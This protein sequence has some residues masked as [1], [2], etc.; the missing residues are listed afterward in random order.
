MKRKDFKQLLLEHIITFNFSKDKKMKR[1]ETKLY[2]QVTADKY[3]LPMLVEDDLE[4][5]CKKLGISK[6][7]C[8]QIICREDGSR[9]GYRIV[10]IVVNDDEE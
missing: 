1:N 6:D 5:F 8:W 2:I 10:R 4:A 9:R 3:E 7:R